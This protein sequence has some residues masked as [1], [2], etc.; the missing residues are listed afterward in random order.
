MRNAALIVALI[1]PVVL[2]AQQLLEE[3][4]EQYDVAEP[5]AAQSALWETFNGSPS[6]DAYVVDDFSFSGAKS[7]KVEGLAQDIVLPLNYSSGV[8]TIRWKMFV[9]DGQGGYFNLM[10]EWSTS[11]STQWATQV[12]LGADRIVGTLSEGSGWT[13]PDGYPQDE[14]FD[15]RFEINTSTDS[16]YLF[17]NTT[18]IDSWIWSSMS[19]GAAGSSMMLAGINFWGREGATP[20]GNEPGLFYVDD[21]TIEGVNTSVNDAHLLKAVSLYPNPTQDLIKVSGAGIQRASI[22]NLTGQIVKRVKLDETSALQAIS[23]TDLQSGVYFVTLSR[24][25]EP[26]HFI[27]ERL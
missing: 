3:N 22:H 27:V 4:F 20:G 26:L 19:T 17:F 9:P 11:G 21:L 14:W 7:L 8:F 13:T 16:A 12:Y 2:N 15:V 23:L 25:G 5:I 18:L 10:H 1:F 6:S 24:N